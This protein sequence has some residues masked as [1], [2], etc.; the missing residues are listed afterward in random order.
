MKLSSA[1]IRL[2]VWIGVI[3]L[4]SL[5]T[6]NAVP[7]TFT[8]NG[9]AGNLFLQ[10]SNNWSP[11]TAARP[12]SAQTDTLQ[13]NGSVGGTLVLTNGGTVGTT[14]DSSPGFYINVA[15]GQTSP[16]T[17]V[18]SNLFAGRI[19]LNGTN[20][21]NVASG[22]GAVNFGN[23]GLVDLILAVAGKGTGET[24][25][26]TNNSANTVTFN[27]DV[28]FVTGG[29]GVHTLLF[30]G[31][32]NFQFNNK[33][34]SQNSGSGSS[35]AMTV[36]GPGTVGLVGT[37]PNTALAGGAGNVTVSGGTLRF[38][39]AGAL[40]SG[41]TLII[42]GGSLDSSVPNLV[43]S[44]GLTPQTWG[45][46]FTFVGTQ[47]L[48]IGAGAVTMAA[49]RNV[50][51]NANTLEVDGIVSG[52]GRL[53]KSGAG[54]LFLSSTMNY[55]GGTII[56]NGVLRLNTF[57]T[58]TSAAENLSVF[59]NGKLDVN[60]NSFTISALNGTNGAID[61]VSGGTPTL[62]IGDFNAG[63]SFSGAIQNT[64][65]SMALVKTGTGSQILGGASTY[66]GG[67]TVSGGSLLVTNATGSG[68]GSGAV[69]VNSGA[70]FGG[71]GTVS[72]T[73]NWQSG[74]LASFT[75]GSPLTVSGS[76]TL[77]G[78]N[79]T[80]NIPGATPLGSGNYTLMTYNTSGS[81]GSFSTAAPT[82]T[83]AGVAAG[84]TVSVTTGSG[85]V[86]LIVSAPSGLSGVWT[87][88]GSGNW[89]VAANW[90]SN[91][92]IP[93]KAGEVSSLGLGSA[94]TTVT[95]DIPV[96]NGFV[97][98]GNTNSFAIANAGNTLTFDNTNGGAALIVING[99]SNSIAAPVSLNDNLAVSVFTNASM[100][101]SNVVSGT[102]PSYTMTIGSGAGTLAL[103]GNNT[104]GP[105]AGSVGTVIAGSATLEL[106]NNNALGAGGVSI[107]SSG[108]LR[109][110]TALT[111][112]NNLIISNGVTTTIN[113]NG[114]I[115]TL[116]GII[117]GEGGLA[118]NGAGTLTLSGAN[119]FTNGIN[120]NVGTIK[121][122][123]ASGI[124]GGAGNG[125]VNMG[126]NTTM[127][128]NG[129][130]P[131]LNGLNSS[132]TAVG[133]TVDSLSGGA[134]TL[135]LGESGSFATYYGNIKN[136]SGSLALV[137][138]GAGNQTLAGTNTYT[139]GT[140]INAGL[141]RVGNGNTNSSA[142]LGTG[143]VV[144]NGTL[145][146]NLVGTN[147]FTNVISGSG[148]LNVAN[149]GLRLNLAAN[150]SAFTGD[151]NVNVGS[152][153]IT[154]ASALG[155]GPKTI[156]AVGGGNSLFTQIHLNG[157]S[158]NI[159][160]DSSITNRLSQST[161]VLINDA[162]SNTISGTILMP[163]GGGNPYIVV[164]NGSFL[165]LAGPITT[166][167]GNN[168]RTL[169]LGG[170]GNGLLSGV[171]S[172]DTLPVASLQ[173]VD[174][175]TWTI[176]SINTAS[177]TATVSGGTLVLNGQWAVAP[178]VVA[179]GGTL[180]GSGLASNL[181]VNAGG[182]FVP[183]GYGSIGSFT[184]ANVL[185]LAASGT[186]YF[187]INKALS[188]ARS[189]TVVNVIGTGATNIS[190]SSG[191]VL[192]VSNLAGAPALAAG[193]TFKL[194][195]Q[196]VTN[197]NLMTLTLPALS[198]GL[199]WTNNL[200]VDGTIA[201]AASVNTNPTNI[202]VTVSGNQLILS[203]PADH[204]GWHLQAQTNSLATGLGTNW[205]TIPGT[206][207]SNGFTNNINN[208]NGSVFYR[209][210]YP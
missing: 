42:N 69:T 185:T 186:N 191:S 207:A 48:N 160:L 195:S 197:G 90:S 77:N 156:V 26:F 141:L 128:L 151:I 171:V 87:N 21:F 173:K 166:V 178:V 104:Y 121:L 183:G 61:T 93:Q 148:I 84:S 208:T 139:G 115:V 133:A 107:Q 22:A 134:V 193:D 81:S 204:T 47:N 123:N 1:A 4:V 82:F 198:G 55:T 111:T 57:P 83:G 98:F 136:T 146:F 168:P 62:T 92:Q 59:G 182:N 16:L 32:G 201:V 105:S 179:S 2:F 95:L 24:H 97:S 40:E 113:N 36:A 65:G 50:T 41:P 110:G 175:G 14:F 187:S 118:K 100:M 39:A 38:D 9:A 200:A 66:S 60:G 153:W 70:T 73:V 7:T 109:A 119:T 102:S 192:V 8:W 80:V 96:T 138:D 205:V 181:T 120:I 17:F 206:D 53:T 140:T 144:D 12:S 164:S 157:I 68:T 3:S 103:Y 145:E 46:D 51:V 34:R 86:Q 196:A 155:T 169:T 117:S 37:A 13:F 67:T 189:N 28:N 124:P 29:G 78:N 130:S 172:D 94:F 15:A 25:P 127:D 202:T 177:G 74:S 132:A 33:V 85:L 152:L 11:L 125:G 199:F 116:S 161:G 149:A 163:N 147:T 108:T 27:N 159:N 99:S 35:L 190:A 44:P 154:N 142:G 43:L 75:Q 106:G 63:G 10:N 79:I 162:G 30:A 194:F 150:N 88:N 52:A 19:R 122:G 31:P 56:S 184:V 5:G 158:G 64:A 114:N 89:S 126:T 210:T 135:T 131:V 129:F 180:A 143:P 101:I 72:G 91:P 167:T 176:S 71:S 165:T 49:N 20:T 203:W 137:K 174:S 209:M 170:A 23:G 18:Q 45:G 6:A 76:V 188:P 54:T 112:P 58:G